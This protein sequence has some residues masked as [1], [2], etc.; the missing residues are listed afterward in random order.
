MEA[1][2]IRK[3]GDKLKEH[4]IDGIQALFT[5]ILYHCMIL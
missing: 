5:Q 2:Y 3:I 1:V 4:T